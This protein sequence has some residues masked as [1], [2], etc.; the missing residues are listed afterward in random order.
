MIEIV[1]TDILN[2]TDDFWLH[3]YL[4]AKDLHYYFDEVSLKLRFSRIDSFKDNL[5]GWDLSKP[6]LKLA[7][8]TLTNYHKR[9]ID[10]GGTITS[11]ETTL[12]VLLFYMTDSKRSNQVIDIKHSIH[13]LAAFNQK[14]KESFVSCWFATD[15]LEEEN[16]AMWDLYANKHSRYLNILDK[17]DITNEF[18]VRISVKWQDLKLYLSKTVENIKAGFVNYCLNEYIEPLMFTKE[19]SYKHEC[20]FRLLLTKQID[21]KHLIMKLSDLSQ[22]VCTIWNNNDKKTL[23]L[24]Q[25]VG[26]KP[27]SDQNIAL[28]RQYGF[29]NLT[30]EIP[31]IDWEDLLKTLISKEE[32]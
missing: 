29:T 19:I 15:R 23:Y 16:R 1:T 26:F 6:E 9:V 4:P 11:L 28:E 7:M 21:D 30:P 18:G 12:K 2:Q 8:D 3:R 24:L 22:I 27:I 10:D 32:L 13:E 20:E 17:T 31:Q 5:E 25:N 14:R